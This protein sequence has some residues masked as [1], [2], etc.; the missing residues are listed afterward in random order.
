MEKPIPAGETTIARGPVALCILA[1]THGLLRDEVRAELERADMILHA[2]DFDSATVLEEL[3]R[4][5]PLYAV[6]GNNDRFAGADG[7]PLSLPFTVGGVR[8][9][10]AHNRQDLPREPADID[11]MIYG[12]SHRYAAEVL[13]GTLYLNP[14]S[15]GKRRFGLGLSLCRMVVADGAFLLERIEIAP[16]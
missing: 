7:L 12:H 11:V 1:D 6:R 8:F 15:C 13:D 4:Y 2:G 9:R 3:R 16:G 10:M 5:G 14:G